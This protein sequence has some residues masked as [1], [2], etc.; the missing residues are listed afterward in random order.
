MLHGSLTANV[1]KVKKRTANEL[2]SRLREEVLYIFS[3]NFNINTPNIGDQCTYEGSYRLMEGLEHCGRGLC[4][5]F[6][7]GVCHGLVVH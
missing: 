6:C 1:G 5:L 2:S 4:L 7:E 3:I